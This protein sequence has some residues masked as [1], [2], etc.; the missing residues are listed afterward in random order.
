[1]TASS[2]NT[3]IFGF[4]II[5]PEI[6]DHI[7]SFHK[8]EEIKNRMN[9]RPDPEYIL[10]AYALGF[11]VEE[12]WAEL[13]RPGDRIPSETDIKAIS[14]MIRDWMIKDNGFTKETVPAIRRN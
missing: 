1:M 13:N 10:Q 11:T 14:K 3:W 9:G 5:L 2:I 7:E 8:L 6:N 4:E 12:I